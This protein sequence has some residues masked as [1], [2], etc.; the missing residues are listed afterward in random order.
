MKH[1][2]LEDFKRLK[3]HLKE[4]LGAYNLCIE[5]IMRLGLRGIEL[6]SLT[7][8]DFD[9]VN[10]VVT[11]QGA[12]NGDRI[13][14]GISKDFTRRLV[15]F[16]GSFETINGTLDRNKSL[17]AQ[18]IGSQGNKETFLWSVRKYFKVLMFRLFGQKY[19][20]VALHSLRHSFALLLLSKGLNLGELKHSLR[21]R[22]IKNTLI[23]ADF[24]L[25]ID[26]KTKIKRAVGE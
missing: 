13:D 22:D 26:L 2:D 7:L 18:L 8:D 20:S 1:I 10:N 16:L 3:N 14:I 4:N 21:H 6:H 11:V 19:R 12:K 24:Q 15:D 23:Y 25:K 9:L 17:F 5:T